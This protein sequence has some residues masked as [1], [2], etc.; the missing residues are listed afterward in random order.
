MAG[1]RSGEASN[2]GPQHALLRFLKRASVGVGGDASGG[3]ASSV[4]AVDVDVGMG[5]GSVVNDDQCLDGSHG[6]VMVQPLWQLILFSLRRL[7][8]QFRLTAPP[9]WAT[10]VQS[11]LK[12][13]A[14]LPRGEQIGEWPGRVVCV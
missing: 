1:C 9:M 8:L 11:W 14:V 10:Q 7:S 13:L 5:G 2:P 3:S 4:F 12:L 6:V